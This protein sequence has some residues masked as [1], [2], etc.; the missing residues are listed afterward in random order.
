MDG[1][2]NVYVLLRLYYSQICLIF[3][4]FGIFRFRYVKYFLEINAGYK[5]TYCISIENFI[6]NFVYNNVWNG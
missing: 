4:G 2:R 3:F 5:S 1:Y 6:V